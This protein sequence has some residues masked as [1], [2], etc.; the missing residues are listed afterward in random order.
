MLLGVLARDGK[1]SPADP[2][3]AYFHFRVATLQ[4]GDEAN[5]L[6][7]DDLRS[8]AAQLGPQRTANLDAQASGFYQH[9]QIVLEFVY[10]SDDLRAR[11][12]AYALA[13]PENGTHTVK[14]LT[15]QPD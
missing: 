9:H 7:H 11:F 6:L 4:G 15:S 10:K 8:L 2:G 13:I 14:I 12:P 5:N 3:A 1:G